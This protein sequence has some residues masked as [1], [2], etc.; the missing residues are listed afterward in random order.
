MK[1]RLG[2]ILVE[3]GVVANKT[4]EQA[5][6]E[7]K[8]KQKIGDYLVEKGFVKEEILYEK[9]S[10]QLKIPLIQ[11]KEVDFS[12]NALDKIPME[13]LIKHEAFPVEISGSLITLAMADPLDEQALKE[14]EDAVN[15]DIS[16][17]FGIKSEIIDYLG[18][19]FSIDNSMQDIFGIVDG[20]HDGIN[21]NQVADL[22]ISYVT[23]Y[24]KMAFIVEEAHSVLTPNSMSKID[25]PINDLKYLLSFIKS[26]VG[27]DEKGNVFAATFKGRGNNTRVAIKLNVQYNLNKVTYWIDV[28]LLENK[29]SHVQLQG[30]FNRVTSDGIYVVYNPLFKKTTQFREELLN[31]QKKQGQDILIHTDDTYFETLGLP[32]IQT[33]L[34]RLPEF[35]SFANTFVLDYGWEF[36]ELE[37]LL[38]LL[39]DRKRIFLHVPFPTKEDFEAYL[40]EKHL[41]HII[42]PFI[43]EHIKL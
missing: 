26:S 5:L 41:H 17:V 38:R 8:E 16:A 10:E 15:L 24:R 33:P 25:I 3:S 9:L 34:A 27:Y 1:K 2:E 12:S 6:R 20:Q 21:S 13:L 28:S 30:V 43:V 7:K 11:L 37:P 23:K 31:Y 22:F 32:T 42:K 18:K 35:S 14:L 39:K 29:E 40:V 36:N 19:Y 4:I